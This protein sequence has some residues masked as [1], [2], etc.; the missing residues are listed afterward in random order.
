MDGIYLNKIAIAPSIVTAII[1]CL[2]CISFITL[3]NFTP[4]KRPKKI[5]GTN[6]KFTN[7]ISVDMVFQ[8]KR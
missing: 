1:K 2:Y 3:T 5:A 8:T 4:T 6:F 7:T